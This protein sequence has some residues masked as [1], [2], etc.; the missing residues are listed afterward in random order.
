[1]GNS[2]SNLSTEASMGIGAGIS[3]V[4]IGILF[5]LYQNGTFNVLGSGA[6]S[7]GGN[8]LFLLLTFVV[9]IAPISLLLFG[10]ILD[11]INRPSQ[12]ITS[13]PSV[14]VFGTLIIGKLFDIS[15]FGLSTYA[16]TAGTNETGI[17]CTLP[18]LE[19]FENKF[20]PSSLFTVSLLLTYYT[21]WS[22]RLY[23]FS[24][25]SIAFLC[26]NVFFP[27]TL[28]VM[29]FKFGP[30]CSDFYVFGTSS[31]LLA[32][33]LGV[34]FSLLAGFLTPISFNPF[35]TMNSGGGGGGGGGTPIIP[36]SATC[37]AGQEYSTGDSS[38]SAGCRCINSKLPPINGRCY[39]QENP[40]Q[41]SAPSGQEQTF[42]AEL[43]KN[44]QLV[45]SE[46]IG[47]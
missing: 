43:Y 14:L 1:M 24:G 42:V 2:T 11:L 41:S 38:G 23:G 40:N 32:I 5:Y 45:S 3:A 7:Y 30:G 25:S 34:V 21:I 6:S 26:V 9:N 29:L 8:L 36:G 18:G 19:W 39:S 17:W 4:L 20:F 35:I 37:P 22:L 12:V 31:I 44:G 16:K 27:L 28:A 15:R 13:L 10:P 33:G 47:K 46:S